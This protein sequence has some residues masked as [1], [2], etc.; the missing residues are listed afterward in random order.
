MK[1]ITRFVFCC[2]VGIIL[3]MSVAHAGGG[4][5]WRKIESDGTVT[6]DTRY[7]EFYDENVFNVLRD[8]ENWYIKYRT[9]DAVPIT[10][11]E[12]QFQY[13]CVQPQNGGSWYV[14]SEA[15]KR[16]VDEYNKL[17][18]NLIY[19]SEFILIENSGTS[20]KLDDESTYI[21]KAEYQAGKL[22]SN[23]V[24]FGIAVIFEGENTPKFL[25]SLSNEECNIENSEN[26]VQVF[27]S[28]LT[29]E[30][31]IKSYQEFSKFY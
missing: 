4:V 14:S 5:F 24:A 20:F 30:R 18:N 11:I 19:E 10:N 13:D 7:T 23:E 8:G 3:M 31:A 25:I 28:K 12:L 27:V 16:A 22:V 21:L 9:G 2:F 6:V 26:G 29:I 15:M 1:K 17:Q